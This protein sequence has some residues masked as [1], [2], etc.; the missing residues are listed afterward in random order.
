M[1]LFDVVIWVY[2]GCGAALAVFT[3]GIWILLALWL[4]KHREAVSLPA[5]DEDKWPT[6]VVQLPIYN[7]AAVAGRLL[8]AVA[9]MDYPHDR[10]CV[11]VLDDSD[12][13][14]TEVIAQL[15]ERY[16]T[17][18]VEHTR[19]ATRAD[20]KAGALAYG[21]E[22]TQAEFVA[23]FDADFVPPP[24][25][26][27]RTVPYFLADERLG[28]IQTRWA[29]LNA[30]QNLITRSQ[31]LGI[32]GHFVIEQVARS[33]GGLLASFN[34]T[35]GV[36]RA[37]AIHEAGGWSGESM[38]EDL[39][40]SYRA[41]L[42]GWGYLYL[43]DVA[44]PAELPPQIAAYKRQQARWAKGTTQNLRRL[45]GEVWRSARLNTAQKVMALL[46]LSQYLPQ[47]LLLVMVLLTPVLM[48]QGVLDRLPLVSLGAVSLAAPL[49]Y[50]LSQQQ[51]YRKWGWRLAAFPLLLVIGSGVIFS[52]SV[53]VVNGLWVRGGVFQRTPK[54][55]EQP[56]HDSAYALYPDWKTGVEI[57]LALYTG[58]AAVS[59]LSMM[60][61]IAPFLLL[62][63]LGFGSVAGW[64]LLES[65]RL[66]LSAA[67]GSGFWRN[68][69]SQRDA[70]QQA[71]LRL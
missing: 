38:A 27:R 59:A 52:N 40:L 16:T 14:T 48:W 10:L 34:G 1:S 45:G 39:D 36:W 70:D 61:G 17:L 31:A 43:P 32:D 25:F 62:Q 26:L 21:L 30:A 3:L 63:A 51:L 46:H 66:R 15:C 56:W 29:H 12:D 58:A 7:E 55:S 42:R 47:L 57:L 68:A 71:G 67:V 22:R 41:Q 33:R 5:V 64:G 6:V 9:A 13:C 19:R 11:Q 28:I 60:P 4:L 53:A 37:A 20:Y 2:V 44:V 24:D 54:F 49:M 35:G 69:E 18:R 8:D 65:W 50:A 23:I